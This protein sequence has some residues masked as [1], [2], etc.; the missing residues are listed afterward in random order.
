MTA[1]DLG[2]RMGISHASVFALERREREGTVGLD[3]L[4][5]AAEAMDSTIVYAIVP[6]RS[7]ATTV[8]EQ[9]ERIADAEIQSVEQTM[10]L[11]DQGTPLSSEVRE[12]AIQ[13]IQGTRG[14]WSQ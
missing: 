14:L 4:R 6:R 7:L 9:A 2:Q 10:A 8:R 13:R 3:S 12:Q 1:G 11:E 5:R